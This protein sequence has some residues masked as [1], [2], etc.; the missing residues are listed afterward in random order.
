MIKNTRLKVRSISPLVA[1]AIAVSLFAFA[2]SAYAAAPGPAPVD[3]G[4]ASNFAILTKTGITDVPTSKVTGNVGT[5]P[6]TGA[7]DLLKCTEVTGTVYSDDAA[8]PQPCNVI[9]PSTL[10][11]AVLDMQMAYTD[12]AGRIKPD[13]TELGAG[14]IGGKTLV[15]GL[16]KW[17][18]SV[19]IPTDV[20]LSGGSAD[21][22]IFQ[23]AGNLKISNGV[24]V[25]L[26]GGAQAKNIF[27]QVGGLATLGTTAHI[28]GIVLS[29]TMIA[30]QTG[31]SVNG[32]LFAQTA[33]TLQENVVTQPGTPPVTPP[34]IVP[35]VVP[36]VI[37]PTT[38]PGRHDRDDHDQDD[39]N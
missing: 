36:P 4:A 34:V 23:I 26:A 12:A 5:S 38:P 37:P 19:T 31:A 21:V 17:G 14:N 6:I 35:P 11:A 1:G 9:S 24:K 39:R 7:A 30:V 27:W 20:T 32:R 3:L 16:Y 28:E 22:W 8:G 2:G 13:Y 15:P 29:K 25:H 18:T 33:V 10:T